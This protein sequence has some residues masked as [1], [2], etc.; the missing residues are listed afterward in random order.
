MAKEYQEGN[1]KKEK[2]FDI[3]TRNSHLFQNHALS[4]SH[5]VSSHY[6]NLTLRHLFL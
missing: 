4:D 5:F 2:V 6:H 1:V 3:M